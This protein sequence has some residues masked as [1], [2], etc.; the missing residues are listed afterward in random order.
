MKFRVEHTFRGISLD[1][2]EK[3]YFDEAF[4]IELCQTV[5]LAR[6]LLDLQNEGGTLRRVVKIG[7]ERVLP[8]PAA[9]ILGTDR[10][11]Y[12]EHLDYVF[13]SY[14]A[15]WK[16]ISSVMSDKIESSGTV[17]F[18]KAGADG[19]T[20][21]VQGDIKVRLFAVGKVVEKIIVAETE[22]S[23]TDA[24]QFTQAWIDKGN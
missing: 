13:G 19:V 5:K 21:V 7:P 16:T 12:E 1:D 17:V 20:R 3:L 24:A 11:D 10:I 22:K 15:S 6:E 8:M 9:K 4:N 18:S 23:Y 2:Y 14:R